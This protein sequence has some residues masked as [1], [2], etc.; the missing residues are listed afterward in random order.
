MLSMLNQ[1]ITISNEIIEYQ[2]TLD[3]KEYTSGKF[4]ETNPENKIVGLTEN[5]N[6]SMIEKRQQKLDEL[7]AKLDSLCK[8]RLDD[9]HVD[10]Y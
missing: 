6:I 7:S 3:H 2:S 8:T 9:Q 5:A 1:N 4:L 10:N